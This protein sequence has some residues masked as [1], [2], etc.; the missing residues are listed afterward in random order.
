MP[1]K[2][3]TVSL[4]PRTTRKAWQRPAGQPDRRQRGRAGVA[5][6]QRIR[7]EEPLCRVCLAEG[8]TRPTTEVDHIVP[9]SQGGTDDRGNKQGLCDPCH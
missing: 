9:L 7:A 4:R 8:R 6:R 5:E 1:S 2:P 3:P